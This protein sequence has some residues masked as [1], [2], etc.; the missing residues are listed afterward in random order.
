MASISEN[1]VPSQDSIKRNLDALDFPGMKDMVD[2]DSSEELRSSVPAAW[3]QGRNSELPA[4]EEICITETE[5]KGFIQE[6]ETLNKIQV[7][8]RDYDETK[9]KE[10]EQISVTTYNITSN[11]MMIIKFGCLSTC[12]IPQRHITLRSEVYIFL[13][14]L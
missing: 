7:M 10:L 8:K 11:A 1:V 9:M 13:G 14:V 3:L 4:L 2:F 12:D 5:N 6:E